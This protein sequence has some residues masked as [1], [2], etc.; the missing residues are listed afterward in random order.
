MLQK[1]IAKATWINT[2]SNKF[3]V[4]LL[5]HTIPNMYFP[6]Q[7]LHSATAQVGFYDDNVSLNN[8]SIYP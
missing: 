4:P 1:T 7:F 3:T 5:P 2:T 6:L 8:G